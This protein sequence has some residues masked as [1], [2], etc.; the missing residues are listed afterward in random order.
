MEQAKVLIPFL[1]TAFDEQTIILLRWSIST[2]ENNDTAAGCTVGDITQQWR[3]C[4]VVIST[5]AKPLNSPN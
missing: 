5:A 2:K 4:D 1:W 3:Q